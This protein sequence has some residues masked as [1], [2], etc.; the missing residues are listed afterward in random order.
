MGG[1]IALITDSGASAIATDISGGNGGAAG[2]AGAVAGN[3]GSAGVV[4]Q[5]GVRA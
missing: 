4:R 2:G 5:Y 1:V 3:A